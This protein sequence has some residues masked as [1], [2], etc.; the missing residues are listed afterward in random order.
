MVR[1]TDIPSLINSNFTPDEF[2]ADSIPRRGMKHGIAF[3]YACLFQPT[4]PIAALSISQT[5]LVYTAPYYRSGN[6]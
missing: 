5:V 2:Q 3:S 4:I 1:V 6:S